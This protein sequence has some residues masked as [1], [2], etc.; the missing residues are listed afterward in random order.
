M[1]IWVLGS[2]GMLG[3]AFLSYC[4]AQ[5]IEAVGTSRKEADVTQFASLYEIGQKIAPSHIVNC[6]A[7]TDVDRAE[8]DRESA[9]LVNVEGA[10]NGAKVAKALSLRYIHIS[11]DYVFSGESAQAYR[12]EDLCAPINFYGWTKLQ[13]EKAV[14]AHDPT[15]CVVRTSWV[16]GGEGKNFISSL[17]QWFKEKKSL[18]VVSDQ[19][20]KPTYCKD[21]S[22]A[23]LALLDHEGIVHFANQGVGSR[24]KIALEL[25]SLLRQKGIDVLC[26]EI[27]P[28]EAARFPTLAPRPLCSVL[29]TT[30]FE[31]MTGI[32]PRPWDAIFN[33]LVSAYEKRA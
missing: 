32:A 29:D 33:E 26:E 8:L 14:L 3:K 13:G 19:Y 24:Y 12:E 16:F 28:V 31:T 1:K 21:L 11:S 20:G 22:E 23:I 9:F 6:A 30:H 18:T 17:L 5:G 27:I 4:K 25:L 15:A 10:L 2:Q 7:F